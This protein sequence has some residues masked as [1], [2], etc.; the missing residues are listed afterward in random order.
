VLKVV[1][2]NIWS[3]MW[4][5]SRGLE[6]WQ[7]LRSINFLKIKIIAF[8]WQNIWERWQRACREMTGCLQIGD[9]ASADRWQSTCREMASTCREMTGCLQ[10]DDRVPA[11]RWQ[12]TC[13]EMAGDIRFSFFA[14]KTGP[15][16][17]N[18][19]LH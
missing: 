2:Y 11:D 9:R 8:I 17:S 1:Y 16:T 13:G 7:W 4:C 10:R 6:D 5:H 18:W 14:I 15:S 19:I 3:R 12:G